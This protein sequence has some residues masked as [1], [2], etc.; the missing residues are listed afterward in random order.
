VVDDDENNRD[1]LSRQIQR[2][3]HTVEMAS[4]GQQALARVAATPYDLILLDILM[5][6][7][8]GYS[9]LEQLKASEVHH[10]IPIIM[11]SALDELDTVVR[12]IAMG[13]E[14]YL[15]KPCDPIL[16]RAR[17]E[18]SL[19]KKHLRD[20]EIDYLKQVA[21]VTDAAAQIEAGK[22]DPAILAPVAQRSDSLGQLA[23][24]FRQMA[25]EVEARE[26]RLKQEVLEIRIEI[27][28]TKRQ[29]QVSEITQHSSFQALK[30]QAAELK[31]Q[32]KGK[33][34]KG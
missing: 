19:E 7:L 26:T 4:S 11:I 8:P 18:A 31:R 21:H 20:Q 22:F 3:G 29:Q 33:G 1:L 30:Q 17:V 5:P 28:Q 9:V 13:A 32:H 2:Q 23:R 6:D 15:P 16:L 14:D 12:C 27:D 10:H 34:V 24:V 25:Q